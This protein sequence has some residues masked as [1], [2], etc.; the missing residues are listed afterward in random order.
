MSQAPRGIE[1]GAIQG[2]EALVLR[3][4]CLQ[5]TVLPGKGADIYSFVH[6]PTGTEL[7]FHAPWGLQPPGAPA[8]E[9]SGDMG[10]LWNYEGGWQELF[11]SANDAC[12]HG[13]RQI[14]FHGE[15]ATLPW[16]WEPLRDDEE[17][18]A[19]RLRVR[20]RQTPFTLARVM[21]LRRGEARLRL[22]ETVT[23]VGEAP[24]PFVWGHHCVLGP[25]FL[26]AG[27]ELRT[28]A[29]T[30]MTIPEMWEET[31]RL[32][33]GQQE[34]WPHARLRG[35]GR[36]DLRQVPG[37]EAGSHD[38]VYLTDLPEGW[39][40]VWNPH[41]RLG[42]RLEWDASLFR[43]IIS[44]QPY[45][46]ARAMPLAGAYALG[47]E[48]WTTRLNLEQAVQAGEARWIDPGESF[49]TRLSAT[50]LVEL[51]DQDGP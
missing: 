5:V 8:R 39:T 36:V 20:C 3:N 30:L 43:W 25:P 18:V 32:E 26:E 1:T 44:W 10:F 29:K 50:I 42:F 11:P 24:A 28:P 21:R 47:I 7:L 15:V 41:R 48:P 37:T 12:T 17:E 31:A 49:E 4:G 34:P 40:E 6:V 51:P 2:W 45:G 46:G 35:G 19:V 33:P 22:A 16:E 9:G 27:C 14:P 13:D 23:N 38:D